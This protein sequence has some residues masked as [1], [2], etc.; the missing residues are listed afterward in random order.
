[1]TSE[2]DA[3]SIGKD[4]AFSNDNSSTPL[5]WSLVVASIVGA[6]LG[7]VL[8]TNWGQPV[9][10]PPE[11][12]DLTPTSPPEKLALKDAATAH[13]L[14]VNAVVSFTMLAAVTG[15]ALCSAAAR[16][17]RRGITQLIIGVLVGVTASGLSGF[18]GSIAGENLQARLH[19]IPISTLSVGAKTICVHIT[20][21]CLTGMG[22]C[23]SLAFVTRRLNCLV[24]YV[25]AGAIGGV[26]AGV[27]YSP[28]AAILFP[29]NDSDRL[30]PTGVANGLVWSV[31][32][33]AVITVVLVGLNQPP[34]VAP[35]TSIRSE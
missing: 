13:M 9:V 25:G 31:L 2:Q 20:A 15:L 18:V 19:D 30:V 7:F 5:S 11:L 4:A 3:L 16:T 29:I 28:L 32:S 17:Y 34:K 1:M 22:L 14:K 23:G 24:K 6:A 10:I 35:Q 26:L 27:L 8:L 21:W 12:A 33:A